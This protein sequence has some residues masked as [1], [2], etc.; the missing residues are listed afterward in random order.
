MSIPIEVTT[1]H[2]TTTHLSSVSIHIFSGRM[3]YDIS[4]PLKRTTVDRC[5][6]GVIDDEGYA[7]AV[8]DTGELLD[9]EHLTA[10]V[11]DSLAK[12]SLRVRTE[13]SI[14]LFL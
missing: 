13:S 5:G 10:R 3:G 8:G 4:A 2:D 6:E 1:I 14:D 11:R 7:V 9:I 12:Q